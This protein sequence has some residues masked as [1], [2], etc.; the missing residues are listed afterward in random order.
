M[1]AGDKV[2]LF[3]AWSHVAKATFERRPG[4]G[5]R[6]SS[7]AAFEG[8]RLDSESAPHDLSPH[9]TARRFSRAAELRGRERNHF[10]R[11]H[12]LIKANNEEGNADQRAAA[13][14]EPHRDC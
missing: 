14:R 1:A 10:V 2:P 3:P 13:R 4:S 8:F 11:H 7:V 5:S 9:S 6:C 12:H